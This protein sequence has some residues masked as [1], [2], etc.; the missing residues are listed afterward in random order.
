MRIISLAPSNTEI[1]FAL[2]AG[3]E[4]IARTPDCT[5]PDETLKIPELSDYSDINYIRRFNADLILTATNSQEE[6]AQQLEEKGLPVAHLAP[7]SLRGIFDSISVVGDLTERP[8]QASQLIE[9]L[10]LE[11][12]KLRLYQWKK[13]RVYIEEKSD[14]PTVAGNWIP[15]IAEIAG[16]N[17]GLC[18][19]GKNSREIS[20]KEVAVF[21]PQIIIVYSNK[22]E[23]LKR[24]WKVD[25]L[26]N[27]QVYEIPLLSSPGPR[28]VMGC[29]ELRKIISSF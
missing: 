27:K 15:D 16:A 13:P 23:M 11:F 12:E 5:F 7:K 22:K 8:E 17:Y 3:H 25:A 19:G 4:V 21:D 24:K 18:K 6:L 28:L 26:K 1:L 2:G 29:S 9:D 14:P 10:N 20:A